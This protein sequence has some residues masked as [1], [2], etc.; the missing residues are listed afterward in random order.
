MPTFDDR[1]KGF[2]EKYAHDKEFEF[3][4]MARRNKLLGL[5][6]AD[7]MGLEGEAT[8]AFAR[9]VIESDFEEPGDEDV[10][11]KVW[12]DLQAKSV[13]QSE[14]QVRTQ[15]SELLEEAKRQLFED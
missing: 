2:E 6:A 8:A 10:F 7:L 4:V 1:E 11:K 12:G 15:M 3:K 14:H 9:E 5:W 13:D